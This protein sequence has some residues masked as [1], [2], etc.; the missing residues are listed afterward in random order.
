[1]T[2]NNMEAPELQEVSEIMKELT[3]VYIVVVVVV[4]VVYTQQALEF[5][6]STN[7]KYFGKEMV[8]E[9][10]ALKGTFQAQIGK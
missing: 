10:M 4:V 5:I 9:F 2:A 3:C 1:M 8:S 6:E 7:L